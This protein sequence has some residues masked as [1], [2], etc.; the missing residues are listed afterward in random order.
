MS[1]ASD[2]IKDKDKGKSGGIMQ[3]LRDTQSEWKKSSFPSSENVINTTLI[4]IISVVIF[5]IYL[6]LVD[7]GW[8]FLL[9]QL[10]KV[11]NAIAGI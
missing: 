3:F 2:T 1:T 8:V 10:A 9:D 5:T 11:V 7:L 4:V 6:Y